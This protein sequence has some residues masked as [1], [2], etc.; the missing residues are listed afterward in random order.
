MA[1]NEKYIGDIIGENLLSDEEE[2]QLSNR[3]KIGDA[4]ALEKL[5][6]ANLTFVV[7]IAHQ[8]KEQG[9]DEDDLISEGNIGMM[10]AAQKFDGSKGIRF[11]KFAA[12][13]IRKAIEKSIKEQ[14]TLYKVPKKENK[15]FEK[16]RAKPVS[17][18][19]PIPVGSNNKLT[20]QNLIPNN[21][22]KD[23]DDSVNSNILNTI[24]MQSINC[25]NER[26]K[27]VI[28]QLYGINGTSLTMAEVATSLGLKRERVRQ[29]RNTALRKLYRKMR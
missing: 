8:Y 7:S 19:Q 20:L 17:L 13:Y 6:K 4:K 9:L 3:I 25:L 24:L 12:P 11:V 1:V 10:Y 16:K 18:D 23:T 15:L 22:N 29:I 2:V 28:T 26:E 21:N 27:A 14:T 5:T